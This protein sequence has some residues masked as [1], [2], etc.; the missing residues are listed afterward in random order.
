[1]EKWYKPGNGQ[2]SNKR[3]QVTRRWIIHPKSLPYQIHIPLNNKKVL[4]VI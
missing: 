1:L 2:I 3:F 4:D